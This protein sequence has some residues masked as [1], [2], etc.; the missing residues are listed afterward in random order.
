MFINDMKKIWII[1]L[2]ESDYQNALS[3][4][5]CYKNTK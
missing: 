4:K 1:A 2:K 3:Q 5:K